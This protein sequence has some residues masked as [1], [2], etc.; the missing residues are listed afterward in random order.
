M[1]KKIIEIQGIV[2]R[3]KARGVSQ[4]WIYRHLV[5][6]VYHISESTYN[7]YLAINAKRELDLLEQAEAERKKQSPMLF[8]E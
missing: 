3:E 2:L 5:A 8:D 6:D 1:L 7:N 4:A